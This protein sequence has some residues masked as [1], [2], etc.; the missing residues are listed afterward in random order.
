[1]DRLT[2]L[3]IDG[4]LANQDFDQRKRSL[5]L[6]LAQLEDERLQSIRCR[7]SEKQIEAF[8]SQMKSLV[9]LYDAANDGEK[10]R[11]LEN[12]FLER[13]VLGRQLSFK[14]LDWISGQARLNYL[15]SSGEISSA[16]SLLGRG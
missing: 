12:I 9:R 6:E 1:M 7:V 13:L 11:L 2:D 3:L 5:A 8:L 4:V 16:Q 14:A 10:R 15:P